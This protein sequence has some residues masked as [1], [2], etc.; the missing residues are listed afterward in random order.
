MAWWMPGR[1]RRGRA[2]EPPAGVEGEPLA[3]YYPPPPVLWAAPPPWAWG[4]L[5]RDLELE[6]LRARRQW[7][8]AVRK[9]VEEELRR[10]EERIREL[11]GE[12]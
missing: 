8:L 6:F 10:L 9:A 7:L 1:G 11:E 5:P 4:E 2:G 12:G 3:G